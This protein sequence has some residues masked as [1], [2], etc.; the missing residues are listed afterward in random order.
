MNVRTLDTGAVKRVVCLLAGLAALA[1]AICSLWWR[2]AHDVPILM[3][4]ARLMTESHA[5]PYRDFFDMNLPGTYWMMAGLVRFFG[6]SDLAVRLFDLTLLGFILALTFVGLKRWGMEAAVLGVCLVALRYF[7]GTWRFSLQREYL[8]LVPLSAV[9]AWTARPQPCS[10]KG[11]ALLGVLFAWMA[12]IKPQLLIFAVPVLLFTFGEKL[13]WKRFARVGLALAV[14]FLLPWSGCAV[15]LIWHGAWRPFLELVT[16]YWPL[17]GQMSGTHEVLTGAV[18]WRYIMRGAGG[19]LWTWYPVVA[20]IGI[21]FWAGLGRVSRQW[22]LFYGSLVVCSMLLPCFSGQFW[23]YH[24]IPFY[25]VTLCVAAL[26]FAR[27]AC[28]KRQA[29]LSWSGVGWGFLLAALCVG[30]ALPRTCSEAFGKGVVETEKGGIPDEVAG[31]L[32]THLAAGDRVQPLDWT[33]GAVHGMLIAH[34]LPATRFLYDF[35]FYHHVSAQFI[36]RLRQEF[37]SAIKAAPPR[38]FID[39]MGQLRPHG[40]G[41]SASF[42]EFEEWLADHY[43]VAASKSGYR[44]WERN[45]VRE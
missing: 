27:P 26:A 9:L 32:V 12:L 41:T 30:I 2:A 40:E 31:Y 17:Y 34:A 35:H 3:Y 24:R 38:F 23:E 29:F 10:C 5:V 13:G 8:A 21:S 33:G 11:G 39:T 20:C 37:L 18:R 28:E 22:L 4:T 42:K 25:Y 14:G 1:C 19:V 16:E 6:C 45:K 15:W 7:A 43:H 36:Q 44:I